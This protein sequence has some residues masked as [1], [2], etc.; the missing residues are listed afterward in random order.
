MLLKDGSGQGGDG[1]LHFV[2]ARLF[3]YLPHLHS[4]IHLSCASINVN[5][6]LTGE[7]KRICTGQC[8]HSSACATVILSWVTPFSCTHSQRRCNRAGFVP[9][10]PWPSLYY[11]FLLAL[12]LT[13]MGVGKPSWC[14][15]DL[16]RVCK[17]EE[18]VIGASC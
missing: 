7:L 4:P 12:V 2:Y 8:S 5:A 15:L 17:S 13:T 1:F 10:P 16:A 18:E 6:T 14:Q 9:G 11:L 3:Q